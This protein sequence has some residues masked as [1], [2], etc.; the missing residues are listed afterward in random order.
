MIT[1]IEAAYTSA[2]CLPPLHHLYYR[3]SHSHCT[4]SFW[5]YACFPTQVAYPSGWETQKTFEHLRFMNHAVTTE[6]GVD[7]A[8][9][10]VTDSE[11]LGKTPK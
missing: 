3:K 9:A 6:Y 1:Q 5:K 11:R 4:S 10:T 8:F 7:G 2:T